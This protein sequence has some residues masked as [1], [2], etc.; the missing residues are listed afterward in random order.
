MTTVK[1]LSEQIQ[2]MDEQH[3]E[4]T[5]SAIQL[6]SIT[7]AWAHETIYRKGDKM[8]SDEEATE[9]IDGR[10]RRMGLCL[11]DK[12]SVAR[13]IKAIRERKLK[14]TKEVTE[15]WEKIKC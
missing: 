14:G 4:V 13:D 1:E 15:K 10:L 8:V 7:Q 3:Y 5:D 6:R 9:I 2:I 12:Q 11:K